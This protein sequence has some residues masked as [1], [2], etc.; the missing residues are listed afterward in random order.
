MTP[1]NPWRHLA[2]HHPDVR[3]IWTRFAGKARGC[4]DGATIW[5]DDRMTQAQRRVTVC[6]E[7]IHIERGIIPAD[8]WEEARVK[9]M[10]AERLIT[11]SQLIDALRWHR[12]PSLS[13]LAETLWVDL[14]TVR[15]RLD[16]L[17]HDEQSEIEAEIERGAA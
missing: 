6:H 2:T 9:R 16:T 13:G 1:H 7:T 3:V 17:G 14:T 4:T 11:T 15:T 12:H 10:T 5:L 8:H